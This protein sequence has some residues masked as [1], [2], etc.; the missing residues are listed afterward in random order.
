MFLF[1]LYDQ[2]TLS[3]SNSCVLCF[4]FLVLSRQWLLLILVTHVIHNVC[5]RQHT[6]VACK[7]FLTCLSTFQDL[8]NIACKLFLTCSSTFQDLQS[9]AYKLF[10]ACLSIFQEL[11]PYITFQNPLSMEVTYYIRD[12]STVES[13]VYI[14]YIQ[15]VEIK[16]FG[17]VRR[18]CPNK[19]CVT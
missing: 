2:T 6:C 19:S 10:L 11:Q 12:F 16:W 1:S 13:V 15:D 17:H 8:Q 4:T 18:Q 3:L 9:I 14:C 5:I 7:L